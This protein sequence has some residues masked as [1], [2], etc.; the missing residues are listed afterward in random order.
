MAQDRKFSRRARSKFLWGTIFFVVTLVT[1]GFDKI[2]SWEA[3]ADD[4]G[5]QESQEG[6]EFISPPLII[7]RPVVEY[8]AENLRDPFKRKVTDIK[9]APASE[10]AK[11]TAAETQKPLP[12][13]EIQGIV[14]GGTF[15]QAIIENKVVKTGDFIKIGQAE[16]A[17]IINIDKEGV[18]VY[19]DGQN[20]KLP[21]PARG[22]KSSKKPSGG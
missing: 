8:Q 1:C 12:L 15:P 6:A 16:A 22:D 14:W 18:T 5:V 9:G 20:Y 7:E 19:F 21:S 10:E 13:L 2:G 3:S 17:K 4:E 11:P